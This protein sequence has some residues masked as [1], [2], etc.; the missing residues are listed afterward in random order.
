MK[1]LKNQALISKNLNAVKTNNFAVV[2]SDKKPQKVKKMKKDERLVYK[3]RQNKN[4][5]TKSE[6]PG[7]SESRRR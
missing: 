3:S 6:I 2:N 1:K 7:P 4:F 5:G